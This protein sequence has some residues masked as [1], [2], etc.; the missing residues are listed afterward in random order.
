TTGTFHDIGPGSPAVVNGVVYVT[1]VRS[2]YSAPGNAYVIAYDANGSAN[3][4]GTVC[5]P[6]WWST[7]AP[8]DVLYSQAL[9]VG[10]GLV[11][12]AEGSRVVAFDVNGSSGCSG[13]PKVCSPVWSADPP[14]SLAYGGP[15]VS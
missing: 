8:T 6:L 9:A 4:A 15:A 14:T 5:S 2:I 10:N 11:Y 7:A 1:G 3:C 13:A 12:A